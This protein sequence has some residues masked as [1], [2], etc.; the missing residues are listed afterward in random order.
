M[1]DRAAIS[2]LLDLIG[3]D[4][5]D[6]VDLIASFADEAPR[7]LAAM[8]EAAQGG[9]GATVRRAAHTL[10]SNARDLGALAFAAD[11]AAL[12]AD[13]SGPGMVEGLI[14]R[15][16]AITGQWPAVCAALMVEIDGAGEAN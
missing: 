4:R 16:A 3:G 7:H 1:L 2:A 15:V 9:D 8:T 11:C 13:L 12:E 10:K 5:A 14:A 6:L